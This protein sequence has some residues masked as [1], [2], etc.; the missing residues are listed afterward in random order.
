[1]TTQF[2]IAYNVVPHEYTCRVDAPN[3]E[4]AERHL[5]ALASTGRVS[6]EWVCDVPMQE[7]VALHQF[8][9]R[10]C[11]DWYDGLPDHEDGGGPYES[12]TLYTTPPDD[13]ALLRQAREALEL[14]R[15]YIQ[16]AIRRAT[17]R[18]AATDTIRDLN[19]DL[20]YHDDTIAALRG[21]LG[22]ME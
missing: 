10:G 11:A 12:R 15:I 1:M 18:G 6:G 14:S 9:K 17:E 4:A 16:N 20:S 21:R 22:E 3:W 8:R 2:I 19:D 5:L 7:P 13:T